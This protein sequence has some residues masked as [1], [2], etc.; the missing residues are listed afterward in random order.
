MKNYEFYIGGQKPKK[1]LK[2]YQLLY[3]YL[4]PIWFGLALIEILFEDDPNYLQAFIYAILGSIYAYGLDKFFTDKT[5]FLK[6]IDGILI[7]RSNIYKKIKE[8]PI[9]QIV[10]LELKIT[11]LHVKIISGEHIIFDGS[12]LTYS[13]I[14]ELKEMV[15]EIE[16]NAKSLSFA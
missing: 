16:I 9:N 5:P 8:I 13:Q 15:S 14:Q 10:S 12:G 11:Q 2:F 6:F 3:Q 7:V 1:R 4:I